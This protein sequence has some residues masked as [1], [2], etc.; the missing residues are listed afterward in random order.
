MASPDPWRD[1]DVVLVSYDHELMRW[2]L[3]Y[4]RPYWRSLAGCIV[5]LLALTGLLFVRRRTGEWWF[6]VGVLVLCLLLMS[7]VSAPL[8]ASVEALAIM[9]FPWRLLSLAGLAT[10]LL[11]AGVA[12][13]F[14]TPATRAIGTALIIAF[15]VMT[16]A[17]RATET[18]HL[19]APSDIT[20]SLASVARFEASEPA[21]G[22]GYD[23]SLIHIS[24]PT[25]PY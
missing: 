20:L 19:V 11:G 5:L 3:G 16:Q 8:W 7:P 1:D 13:A 4:A 24:E 12:T 23:L 17:P 14:P 10:A 22:A 25:R 6:W 18:P 2:L 15:I 21:Y 9:Q